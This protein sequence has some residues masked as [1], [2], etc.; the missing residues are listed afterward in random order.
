MSMMG[1]RSIGQSVSAPAR[2]SHRVVAEPLARCG[3]HA[4]AALWDMVTSPTALDARLMATDDSST[5]SVTVL[6]AEARSGSEQA[7]PK[8][9]ETLYGDLQRI[10]RRRLKAGAPITMLDTGA[11][12]HESF[13]RFTRLQQL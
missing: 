7:L 1:G 10:A 6:L 9:F 13:E 2:K 11:L 3:P 5:G 8:L 12:V 4:A